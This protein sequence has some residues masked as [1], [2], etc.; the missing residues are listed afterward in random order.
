MGADVGSLLQN[1]LRYLLDVGVIVLRAIWNTHRRLCYGE[2]CVGV[3]VGV[4][5]FL[6]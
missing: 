5:V 3:C 4:C 1:L 6:V 2:L